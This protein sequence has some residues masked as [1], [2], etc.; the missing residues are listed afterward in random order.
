[1]T[2]YEKAVEYDGHLLMA[3]DEIISRCEEDT[4]A[5]EFI[6]WLRKFAREYNVSVKDL[7]ARVLELWE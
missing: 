1:M 4:P 5:S 2:E 3:A 6:Y 7:R